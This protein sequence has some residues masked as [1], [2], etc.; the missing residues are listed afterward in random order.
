[1]AWNNAVVTNTGIAMLQQVLG[2]ATLTLD[3][4]VGGTGTVSA[5]SLMA[6][7][8]LKTQKQT[9]DIVGV[10]NETNGKKVNILIVSD[11]LATGY[12]MNQVGIWAHVGSNPSALFA[13]IQDE[14]GIIIPSET[15]IPDFSLNFYVVID[16]SNESE[17]TLSVDTS[18]LVSVGMM[19]TA[20]STKLDVNGSGSDLTAVF[21]QAE[22]RTSIATGEKLSVLFGKIMKWFTD[23][24]EAAFKSVGT[25][26]NDVAAG[27]HG[28][29]AATTSANGFMSSTDKT[30]LN[31]I[32]TGAQVNTITSVA[33]K[34]GAVTLVKADVGLGN[35]DN[36]VDSVKV[37]L[38]A[39]KLSTAR[40]IA[41]T[42]D[43]SGS[44]SFD[45]SANASIAV[46]LSNS[47]ATEGTYTKLTIDTKGRVTSATT[48]TA[49]DIPALTLS[50][51]SDAG[52]AASKTTGN[53]V[54]NVPVIGANGKL[55][56]SIMPALAISDTFVV[57]NQTDMLAVTAQI[58]DIAV[59]T[60]LNKSFIL[61]TEPA[62]TLANWQELLTP[63][64]VVQSVAGKTGAVTLVKADVGLGNV[65][66]TSDANKP[67]STAQQ[68]A[69]NAKEVLLSGASTKTAPID[70]DAIIITDSAASNG[71][72]RTLWSNIKSSLKTYFDTLY[73]GIADYVRQPG[74]GTTGGSANAYTLTPSPAISAYAAGQC[75]AVQIHAANTGASTLNINALGTKN[76]LDSKGNA[77]TSGKLRLNGVY[78]LRYDGTNFILQGEGG[79][80]NALASDLL[81]GKTASTD[82]GD[83]TGTMINNGS[84]GTQNLTTEGAEYTIPAGY[85]NGLGKVKAVIT[86]IAAAV[87]KAGTTVG[88]IAGTFTA[89]ATAAAAQILSG[90]TAY[91]NGSKIT[92]NISS[93]AAATITP[94]TADQTIVAGQYL[95]GAQT[96][97][98][99]ADLVAANIKSGAN[100]F[101]VAGN[102]NVVDTSAGT[103]TAAQLLSGA[104]AFVDGAQ[105]TGTIASKAAATI[106]PNTADQTIVAGQYLSGAQTISGDADLVAPN[107]IRDKTIFGVAGS[108][109]PDPISTFTAGSL[110]I[111]FGSYNG[112]QIEL[113]SNTN[114]KVVEWLVSKGGTIRVIFELMGNGSKIGYAQI[115]INGI[116]IGTA[117]SATGGSWTTFSEDIAIASGDYLQIYGYANGLSSGYIRNAR[118]CISTN[119]Y[120]TQTV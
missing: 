108:V 35:V 42:G 86:N 70:A 28:H 112:Y 116:A 16:F 6:Q 26:A 9:F 33:G 65:D 120:I 90:Y 75:F 87:I 52:T 38:S 44:A 20:L 39:T 114:T 107:I 91:V 34:T 103:A 2:G 61:K 14:P 68:T 71:T 63:T 12:T 22:T 110:P 80:G 13:I 58:G 105:I 59:R 78:T 7:T 62:S 46:V 45:G 99:D 101:G 43:A 102:A 51:I 4:A 37:V 82:A 113:P 24:G 69:L 64:D 25:G 41:L 31:G 94:N 104:I 27:N 49:A 98:G 17:F 88:G 72:K 89:D 10:T 81:S 50:K 85:H 40:N 29:S 60:D 67:V 19:N 96:I 56:T 8:A 66:N 54:G 97:S 1:M 57:A 47:G 11:G 84:I 115:Y 48:L 30:K 95:S 92:G 23:L 5:A 119:P 18:A 117:R 93:K 100:I 21:T 77:M 15:D 32:E 53:A 106:T 3:G 111:Y 76:I 74:Y 55:D 79:S 83:I 109:V 118:L 73:N 36:T